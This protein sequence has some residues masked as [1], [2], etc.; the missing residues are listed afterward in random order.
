MGFST[1]DSFPLPVIFPT[2][3][4]EY[5]LVFPLLSVTSSLSHVWPSFAQQRP[6]PLALCDIFLEPAFPLRCPLNLTSVLRS[7]LQRLENIVYAKN[8][9]LTF[10]FKII[11]YCSKIHI[12]HNL[13]FNLVCFIIIN[14]YKL[15]K[16]M[17]F[18]TFP[19]IYSCPFP[20]LPPLCPL[21]SL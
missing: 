4:S 7:S 11:F 21:P 3:I 18:T 10:L 1:R 6:C 13:P 16:L 15:C 5:P 9:Y 20:L 17:G 8:S 14:T 12:P 19:Y 2:L